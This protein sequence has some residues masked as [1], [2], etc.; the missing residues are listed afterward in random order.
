MKQNIIKTIRI[1]FLI[2]IFHSN[3]LAQEKNFI[4]K[5]YI[6]INQDEDTLVTPNE[7]YLTYT[8]SENNLK[9]YNNIEQVE[10]IIF[11]SFENLNLKPMTNLKLVNADNNIKKEFLKVKSSVSNKDFEIKISDYQD[12]NKVFKLLDSIGLIAIKIDR[13]NYT[14]S[15]EVAEL[16]FIKACKNAK[17]KASKMA[18]AINKQIGEVLY[19]Q[20]GS[21]EN[22]G[23]NRQYRTRSYF[24]RGEGDMMGVAGGLNDNYYLDLEMQKIKIKVKIITRFEIK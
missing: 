4:D 14:K 3:L 11:K 20:T 1:V 6:E 18:T 21:I 12:V 7:I 22:E 24:R 9:K 2:L 8:L 19:I 10:D 17:S 23:E 13:M 15:K 16:M 5:P